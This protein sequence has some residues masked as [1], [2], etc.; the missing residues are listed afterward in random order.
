MKQDLVASLRA[1]LVALLA[2]TI[3]LGVAYPALVQVLALGIGAKPALGLVGQA[4]DDP[5]YFWSR[6][7]ATGP[8]PYTAMTS[9]GTNL[10]PSNPA[11]HEAIVARTGA[12]H[13]ADAGGGAGAAAAAIPTDLVTSSASGLDP[14]ISPEAA[15]YQVP[16]I[17]RLRGFPEERIR[18]LVAA[19]VDPR[20]LGILGD[21]R[22]NVVALDRALD[23][24]ARR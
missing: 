3:L 15:Y 12:I 18:A 8:A 24:L 5:R 16:R 10:A 13:A 6:P 9:S 22:V 20:T 11:L 19:L 7:S 14:H 2:F 1:A 23:A 17:A 21:P 4:I